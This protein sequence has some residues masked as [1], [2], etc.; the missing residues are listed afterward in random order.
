MKTASN[1][2]EQHYYFFWKLLQT[3]QNISLLVFSKTA[4]KDVK[5]IE[6]PKAF[7]SIDSGDDA[8]ITITMRLT[9]VATNSN[10]KGWD[11]FCDWNDHYFW[12]WLWMELEQL[13]QLFVSTV[14]TVFHIVGKI[15]L[16]SF[17]N[18]R[19]STSWLWY[20]SK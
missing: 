10:F 12:N 1:T 17:S 15:I 13:H 3:K 2:T 11:N 14:W 16:N 19:N 7:L 20:L 5:L 6:T 18:S 9:K 4:T 8:T